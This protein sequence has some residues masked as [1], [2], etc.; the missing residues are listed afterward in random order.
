MTNNKRNCK[1]AIKIARLIQR[2]IWEE[3][4]LTCSAGVSYNKFLAKLASDFQKPKG[5]TIVA[6]QDAL[7]FLKALPID[8]FHGVGKKPS[9]R[10]MNLVFSLEKIFIIVQR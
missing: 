1:S 2:D 9:L 10:C 6:P 8:K 7:T 4:K 3:V 5:I